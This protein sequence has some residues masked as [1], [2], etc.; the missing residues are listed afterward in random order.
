VCYGKG[1]VA[2]IACVLVC[3]SM[4]ARVVCY[5]YLVSAHRDVFFCNANVLV[6]CL[7]YLVE[8]V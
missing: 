4:C 6:L 1:C 3:R 2:K 5:K 8:R 7:P